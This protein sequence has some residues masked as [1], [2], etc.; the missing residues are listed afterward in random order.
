VHKH[1][2]LQEAHAQIVKARVFVHTFNPDKIT[3]VSKPAM[4]I[5]TAAKKTADSALDE[6]GVRRKGLGYS[7]I[8]ILSES[9]S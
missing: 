6:V 4:D 7:L 1:S 3:E 9:R 2:S 8:G 5:A